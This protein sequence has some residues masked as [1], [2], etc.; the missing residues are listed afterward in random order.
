M[1]KMYSGS[2]LRRPPSAGAGAMLRWF[3]APPLYARPAPAL[4]GRN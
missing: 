4:A 2:E 3:P 1:L